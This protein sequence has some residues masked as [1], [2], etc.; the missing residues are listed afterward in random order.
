MQK[1]AQGRT[2][3]TIAHRLSTVSNHHHIIVMDQGKIIEQGSHNQLLQLK[4][5][6]H[7]LWSLQQSLKQ[8]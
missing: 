3:I 5:Q 7:Y 2:V 6:Y 1:I 8:Q 4:K